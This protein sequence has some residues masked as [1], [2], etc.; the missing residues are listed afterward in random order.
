MTLPDF[1]ADIRVLEEQT[2]R[3]RLRVVESACSPEVVI[4][5]RAVTAFCSNDYLGLASDPELVEAAVDGARRYGV[6]AGASHLISGHMTAHAALEARLAKFVGM[7]R[8]LYFTSGYL[9]NLAVLPTLVGPGDEIFS[10]QLNHASLID[11]ARLAK[12]GL[13]IYPHVD[14]AALG[15]L[16][17]RS[18]ARRK[19][20]VTDA[21][22]SMDG[23]LAPLADILALCER[24]DAWL[25]T[26]DAHGFGVLGEGGRGSLNHFGL[27]SPH[28]IYMGT[29]GK[30]AGVSGAFVAG[31]ENL[32]EW[33]LQRARSYIFTTA[34]PPLLAH[35][36]IKSLELIERGDQRR[37]HLAE[38]VARLKQ[39]LV[40][41][42][43]RLFPSDTAI[44]PL[45]IGANDETIA[46]AQA[47]FER[48]LWVPGI[49]P[50]TVPQ[51]TSRLRITLSASHT[52][53][54]VDR[55]A[56]ALIELEA[57][58]SA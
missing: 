30:A 47:L 52:A 43:W 46:V 5:G 41:K 53:E 27:A 37:R 51:G 20:V 49:R 56:A 14:L 3:R 35:T 39:A 33:L 26:D 48:G 21:V 25:L 22:F 6:G 23:D 44:Q 40:F 7:D 29:L 4:D 57:G 16:L 10:D 28:L 19:I 13:H 8:A 1:S 15:D 58:Y 24:Y 31:T 34:S 12:A 50:P 38:L 55:L 18:A 45:I 36:L 9:A 54:H 11:A 2:L 42:R 17:A 32:I